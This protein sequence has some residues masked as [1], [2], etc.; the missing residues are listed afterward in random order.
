MVN[1]AE[2]IP[3]HKG[4]KM[5]KLFAFLAVVAL[6][7]PLAAQT[8]MPEYKAAVGSWA[9][10]GDRLYQGDAGSM[11]AKINIKAPQ[12]DV[13]TYEFNARYEGGAEDGHGGF[14]VHVF[15]DSVH[16][17]LSW[18][19]GNSY[20][21]W[22]NYDEKPGSADIPAG[23]SA[24]IYKSVSHREMDLVASIDLNKYAYLIN[25][26]SLKNPLPIKLVIDGKTGMAKIYD[27]TKAG[28][29]YA[30]SLGCTSP[31]SGNW[32]AVR[33]NGLKASFGLPSS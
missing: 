26:D 2:H 29:Y 27:P 16:P 13:M 7:L 18:G 11:L 21:L 8:A 22:L 20:L 17:G 32:V 15:A 30:F 25:S 23:F 4:K 3:T 1:R 33:T 9:I 10:K 5:K 28:Y 31:I 14:G 24:Q 12:N 6:A 19:N